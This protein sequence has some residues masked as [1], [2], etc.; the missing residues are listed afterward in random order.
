M[1][2]YYLG[3]KYSLGK[4]MFPWLYGFSEVHALVKLWEFRSFNEFH[5]PACT[6][7]LE[8]QL[9]F[10][11]LINMSFIQYWSCDYLYVHGHARYFK[12]GTQ[13]H[14]IYAHWFIGNRLTSGRFWFPYQSDRTTE[15]PKM[16]LD[17]KWPGRLTERSWTELSVRGLAWNS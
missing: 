4:S 6:E 5:V 16:T 13:T 8:V 12:K 7:V 1:I 2:Q 17:R 9:K 14:L 11:H 10:D 15:R 3:N